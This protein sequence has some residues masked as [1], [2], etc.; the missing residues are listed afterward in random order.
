MSDTETS[1]ISPAELPAATDQWVTPAPGGDYEPVRFN[2]LKHGILSRLVVLPHENRY[3]YDQVL[4]ALIAEHQPAGMTEH[5]LVE[6]LAGI[7]WRQR[8]VLQA[9]GATINRSLRAIAS[10][11]A[12]SPVPAAAPFERG[13]SAED[14]D[15]HELLNETPEGI[16]ERRHEAEIDLAATQKARAILRQGRSN[17]YEKAQRALLPD[18]L[19]WWE[20]CVAEESYG[21]NAEGLEQFIDEQL[22]PFCWRAMQ[23]A[24]YIPAIQ[25]QTLGEGLQAY[26]FVPLAR[27]ETHLDRKFERTLA[28]LL[29]LRQLRGS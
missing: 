29:K 28:M 24:R 2:A 17:A 12:D 3:E 7:M 19:D 20:A 4:A 11:N 15:L 23:Q 8:R 16:A 27:Y 22:Y 26:R 25:A 6:E 1:V 9:E 5:H 21:A 18:S 14:S 10:S 13:L